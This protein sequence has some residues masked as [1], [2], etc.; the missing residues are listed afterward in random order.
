MNRIQKANKKKQLQEI[1]QIR[2]KT[3][4]VQAEYIGKLD[5]DPQYSLEVDPLCKYNMSAE[6]KKFIKCYTFYIFKD[7]INRTILFK[8]IINRYNSI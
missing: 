6:Q 2:T 4:E 1:A 3:E 7:D 5:S 8:N